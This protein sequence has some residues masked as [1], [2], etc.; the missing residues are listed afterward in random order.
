VS[1]GKGLAIEAEAADFSTSAPRRSMLISLMAA[2]VAMLAGA[3]ARVQPASAAVE[4]S[5]LTLDQVTPPIAPAS[6]LTPRCVGSV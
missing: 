6:P 5:V 4:A 3:G 1:V 2:N